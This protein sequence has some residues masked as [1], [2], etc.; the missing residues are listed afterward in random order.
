MGSIALRIIGTVKNGRTS[1][2]DSGWGSLESEIVLA[3]E[4]APGLTGLEAFSHAL[5]VFYM[6]HDP[7][8]EAPAVVRRPRGRE[9]MPRVGV[10]AQ[11]GR[12]RPNPVGVTAVEVVSVGDDRVRVRGLDAIDGTPVLDLKPYVPD[13]DR[14]ESPR[15]PEWMDTLMAGYFR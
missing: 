13:F 6:E 10:F 5:V 15:V 9:D 11:R 2:A 7:D 14:V 12:M 4:F 8:G 3:P 1:T